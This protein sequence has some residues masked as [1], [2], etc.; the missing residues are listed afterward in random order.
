MTGEEAARTRWAD[1]GG[2]EDTKS[3][4]ASQEGPARALQRGG[5]GIGTGV[6]AVG[7]GPAELSP[8]AQ[9]G[10]VAVEL[11]FEFDVFLLAFAAVSL[12]LRSSLLDGGR[13]RTR[14][15]GRDDGHSAAPSPATASRSPSGRCGISPSL[16]PPFFAG[17]CGSL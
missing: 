11:E 8:A 16:P 15:C 3:A 13:S 7:L 17:L 12:C 9:L 6:A 10:V 2:Y 5:S 1:G 4:L 14:R